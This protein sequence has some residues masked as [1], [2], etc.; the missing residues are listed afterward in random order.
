MATINIYS[1][2]KDNYIG[3]EIPLYNSLL[4]FS[5]N[6]HTSVLYFFLYISG[7]FAFKIMQSHYKTTTPTKAASWF[8]N[9]F[10]MSNVCETTIPTL[11]L[12]NY[13][14]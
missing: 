12:R 14:L 11:Q 1:D 3:V 6:R 9:P 5:Q 10:I 8:K 2:T 7:K 13:P 4:R